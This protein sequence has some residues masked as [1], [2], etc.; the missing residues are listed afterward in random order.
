MTYVQAISVINYIWFAFVLVGP[1]NFTP[2]GTDLDEM[3]E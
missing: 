2:I 3:L 1:V